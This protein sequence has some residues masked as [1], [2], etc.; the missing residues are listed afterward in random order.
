MKFDI[1]QT[2]T[3]RIIAEIENGV[4]PWNKPWVGGGTNIAIKHRDGKP[5]SLLNQFLLGEPGEYLSFK[6]CQDLGGHVKKSEKSRMVVFWTMNTYDKKDA[7][8]NTVFDKDGTAVKVQIPFLKYYNVFHIS[9]C[10]GIEPKWNVEKASNVIDPIEE[11]EKAATEYI[12]RSGVKLEKKESTQAYYQP[13]TDTIVIPLMDQFNDISK[14]YST[15][16]HEMVHSTGHKSRLDR[17]EKTAA[18]G[19]EDYSKEELIAEIG[20]CTILNMLGI[21]TKESFR[22]TT[23]YLQGWLKALKDDKKLIISAAGKAEKAVKFFFGE[24]VTA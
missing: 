10:E 18:F 3:D 15:E 19:N 2:I 5:Y 9:Q 4:I 22:N 13:S 20:A 17:L 23:A 24:E 11:A 21:E 7:A 1:Y 6:E 12:N 14:Y 16:F 8:G